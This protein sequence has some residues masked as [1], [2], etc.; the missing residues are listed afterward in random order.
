MPNY[1]IT[2]KLGDKRNV[3]LMGLNSKPV[4][5][6][7]NQW[8]RIAEYMPTIMQFGVDNADLLSSGKVAKTA[9]E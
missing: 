4:T 9:S 1:N 2:A 3:C 6:Y 5:L 8:A 7:R